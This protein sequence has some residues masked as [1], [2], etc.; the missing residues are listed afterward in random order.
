MLTVIFKDYSKINLSKTV[1][2]FKDNS[3]EKFHIEIENGSLVAM[4]GSEYE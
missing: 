1:L 3:F 2:M 4:G